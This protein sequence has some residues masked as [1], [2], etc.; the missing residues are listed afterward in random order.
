MLL[1]FCL[2]YFFGHSAIN[3]KGKACFLQKMHFYKY[4]HSNVLLTIDESSYF[5]DLAAC[6]AGYQVPP[7]DVSHWLRKTV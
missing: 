3:T 2:L 4:I 1:N 5:Q 7:V 6:L